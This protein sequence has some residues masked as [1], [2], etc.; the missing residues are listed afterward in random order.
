MIEA[1]IGQRFREYDVARRGQRDEQIEQRILGAR[2]DHQSIA[3]RIGDA[4]TKPP[5][6]DVA[7][8][9]APSRIAVIEMGGEPDLALDRGDPAREPA[10]EIG[11]HRLRREIHRQVQRRPWDGG[12]AHGRQAFGDKRAAPD[13]RLGKAALPRLVIGARDGGEIDAES[14]RQRA[15]R[16]QLLPAMQSPACDIRGQGLDDA[17][18]NRAAS[19]GERRDPIHTIIL[20]SH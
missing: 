12:I 20:S 16:R 11:F 15:V 9:L 4:G 5:R 8:G 13:A 10:F 14:F 1:G 7:F 6:R 19:V 2:T 3:A 18:I 17:L